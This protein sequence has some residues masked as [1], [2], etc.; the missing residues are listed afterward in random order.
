MNLHRDQEKLVCTVPVLAYMLPTSALGAKYF[1][2]S[3]TLTCMSTVSA[4]WAGLPGNHVD[5][6]RVC[7]RDVYQGSPRG[8]PTVEGSKGHREVAAE[9]QPNSGLGDPTPFSIILI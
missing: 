4:S 3:G 9:M 6:E 1:H 8:P 2:V 5:S 7:E